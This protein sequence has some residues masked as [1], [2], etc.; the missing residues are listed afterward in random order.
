MKNQKSVSVPVSVPTSASARAAK[1]GLTVPQ[2][3]MALVRA[4]LAGGILPGGPQ[5]PA[6]PSGELVKVT[7]KKQRHAALAKLGIT[8][9]AVKGS[10]LVK[11]N[12]PVDI[13]SRVEESAKLAGV[14]KSTLV[15]A[16]LVMYLVKLRDEAKSR[17]ALN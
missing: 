11:L 3:L 12:L 13:A 15:N 2:Y 8:G 17:G 6:V 1:V 14:S 5:S 9:K 16:A 4:D 10:S 7:T